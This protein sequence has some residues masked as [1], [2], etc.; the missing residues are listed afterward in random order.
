MKALKWLALAA[1]VGVLGAPQV[2][3]QEKPAAAQGK[4]FKIAG[5]IFQD[6]QFFR[7]LSFGMKDAAEKAGAEFLLG[8]SMNKADKEIQ[9]IDGYV[10]KK[11]DAIAVSPISTKSS[12]AKL[13]DAASKGV[14]LVLTNSTIPGNAPSSFIES[15]QMELG[16][17][18]GEA[19]RKY[20]QEKLGG[21]AK[22]AILAYKSLLAEQSDARTNGFKQ[23]IAKLPGVQIV[24]EQDAWLAENA[25]KKASDILTGHPDLDI[26]W[27]AN[28]G[29]TVGS[30]LA[31]KNAGKAGKV[32]VFGT[33]VS[34]QLLGF[35]QNS[36][37]ILQTITA[38]QPYEIG[39][40]AVEA[41]VKVLKG[42]KVEKKI[43]M[44]GICLQRADAAGIKDY[45][46]K[47]NARIA[48]G[49]K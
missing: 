34:Q 5:I 38:Q 33:D 27:S 21:K 16:I 2:M 40:T 3:A 24:V 26:I 4:Q 47:L 45:Q 35:L 9:L 32:A 7:L 28:E 39:F 8:N 44:G 29:G 12:A 15:N 37:N 19:A 43:T 42:E 41:A 18:T 1:A 10:T 17:K 13:N 25:V 31:V 20:I 36:D 14:K 11:V 48:K 22:I 6:D 46:E 23:E 30:V 49:G